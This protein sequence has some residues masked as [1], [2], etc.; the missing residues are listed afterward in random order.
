MPFGFQ[1]ILLLLAAGQGFFLALLILHKYG[2]LF[3]NRFLSLLMLLYS[4]ILLNLLL[5][6]LGYPDEHPRALLIPLG[7]ALL[8]APLHYLYARYLMHY[9]RR[10]RWRDAWHFLP[11]GCYLLLILPVLLQPES[12]PP[13]FP[14]AISSEPMPVDSV[15]F[16]W[17]LVLQGL[18]YMSLLLNMLRRYAQSL[19]ASFPASKTSNWSG[20]AISP[21]LPPAAG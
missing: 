6:E 9:D 4:L 1:N 3:A 17:V 14:R 7:F 12:A 10:F 8:I 2:R 16:N 21:C 5:T 15:L 13:D 18:I 20:C 19:H 11:F